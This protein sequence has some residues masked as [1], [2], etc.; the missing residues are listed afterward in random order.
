M[1]H[2][3]IKAYEQHRLCLRFRSSE[4]I[5]EIPDYHLDLS[6]RGKRPENKLLSF[7]CKC[8]ENDKAI[9]WKYFTSIRDL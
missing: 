4:K 1:N 5:A 7:R 8:L 6:S 3:I 2:L 9:S